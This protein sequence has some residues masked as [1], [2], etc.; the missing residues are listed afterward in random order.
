MLSKAG[1]EVLIKEI[2]QAIPTYTMRVFQLL[3]KLCDELNSLC[4]KFWWGQIGNEKK[5]HWKSWDCL[6]QPKKEGGMGFRDLRYFNL[7]MLAKQGWRL[8][9]NHE[10][11]MFKCFK[12]RYFPRYNFLHAKDSPNSSFVWKSMVS[13][14]PI[15]KSGCCWRV[16]NGESIEATMDKWIPNNPSN[17]ILHP[18]H[19]MEEGWRVP[20]LIDWGIHGWKRDIIMAHFNREEAEAICRIPLS[21]RVVEDLVTWMHNKKGEYSI[22]FGYHLA[23]QVLR[24]ADWA[25]SSNRSERQ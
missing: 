16:G 4:A 3:V 5:I 19:G 8:L 6:T 11:L 22:R 21:R 10:S 14:L 25:E 7:A 2:T 12:A 20:D 17:K 23:R 15:L 1:K 24:K 18:V 13:A 9:K